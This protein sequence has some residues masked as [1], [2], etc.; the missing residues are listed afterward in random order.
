[1][2]QTEVRGCI[3]VPA[4]SGRR[5]GSSILASLSEAGGT[6]CFQNRVSPFPLTRLFP[7]NVDLE[8]TRAFIVQIPDHWQLV[9]RLRQLLWILRMRP[10]HGIAPRNRV[11]KQNHS[12]GTK[13]QAGNGAAPDHAP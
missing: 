10:N 4:V 5:V 3:P 2:I 6:L 12:R 1:M 11:P 13:S 9:L 8:C 7:Q